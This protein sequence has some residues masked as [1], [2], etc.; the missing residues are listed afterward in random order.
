MGNNH[1]PDVHVLERL[2]GILVFPSH[3]GEIP[4]G[5]AVKANGDIVIVG[6][7]ADRVYTA[8]LLRELDRYIWNNGEWELTAIRAVN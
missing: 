1:R 7:G 5:V 4:T 3:A 6:S 8:N 2:P